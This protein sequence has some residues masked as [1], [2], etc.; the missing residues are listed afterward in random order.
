MKMSLYLMMVYGILF[1]FGCQK[2]ERDRTGNLKVRIAHQIDGTELVWD[3]LTYINTSGNRYSVERLQYYISDLKFY[4]NRELVAHRD[5]VIYVDARLSDKS[6]FIL[7]DFPLAYI[8]SISFLIG[9]A[10]KYNVPGGLPPTMEN[11]VMDWPRMMGGG[12]HFLKL[13]GRWA[14]G[15]ETP[16]FAMHIGQPGYQ[17]IAAARFSYR[18]QA[19]TTTPLTMT[20][21]INEWFRNPHPYDF[22]TDGVY[23][24]GNAGL[25]QKL[26][27]NGT[28]VFL[29][30]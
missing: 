28:D 16:G 17:V 23:T 27:E 1:L 18:L 5:T 8:D 9:V 11:A 15:S 20:M 21:N 3:T 2:Q 26:K 7:E 4:G 30:K 10:P 14:D 12:Y 13:E 22:A 6:Q 24:M 29:I 19:Q 25:M